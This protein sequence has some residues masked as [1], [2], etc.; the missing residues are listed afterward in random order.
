MIG[1]RAMNESALRTQQ[2]TL[3]D[4]SFESDACGMGCVAQ[5]DAEAS[6]K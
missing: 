1:V 4:P 6:H 5:L 3:W 2:T